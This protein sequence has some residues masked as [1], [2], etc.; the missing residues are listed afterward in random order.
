MKPTSKHSQYVVICKSSYEVNTVLSFLKG[1]VTHY[2]NWVYVF[3]SE[4]KAGATSKL[5]G[6]QK[7]LPVL[8]FGEWQTLPDSELGTFKFPTETA[9]LQEKNLMVQPRFKKV[10]ETLVAAEFPFKINPDR[11]FG[12]TEQVVRTI[13]KL[14]FSSIFTEIRAPRLPR[15]HLFPNIDGVVEKAENLTVFR[16]GKNLLNRGWF[17][18]NSAGAPLAI[19]LQNGLV[20]QE[21]DITRIREYLKEV[22]NYETLASTK[23][24][25]N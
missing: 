21:G 22:Y 1:K 20:I 25:K 4:K 12:A 9:P 23:I 18:G 14:G 13:N 16:Y 15:L 10:F 8:T 3:N 17:I 6:Y 5:V 24:N 11:I 2:G 7:K 19:T